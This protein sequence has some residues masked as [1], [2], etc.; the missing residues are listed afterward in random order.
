[1]CLSLFHSSSFLFCYLGCGIQKTGLILPK[2]N[3]VGVIPG[4]L[5]SSTLFFI[6]LSLSLSFRHSWI[7][8]IVSLFFHHFFI[9]SLPSF[10]SKMTKLEGKQIRIKSFREECLTQK[11]NKIE[12]SNGS[13]DGY[14][15]FNIDHFI[16]SVS[17][18]VHSLSLILLFLMRGSDNCFIS[19]SSLFH[20]SF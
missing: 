7:S 11:E 9:F 13:T 20:S 12:W 6:H 8:L 2:D 3:R 14:V 18:L 5:L 10:P 17:S 19:P 1:M 15:H 4:F 16:S